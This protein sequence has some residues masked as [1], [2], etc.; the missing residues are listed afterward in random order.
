M[1]G[2]NACRADAPHERRGG[3]PHAF[4]HHP[5]FP[6]LPITVPLTFTLTMKAC[7]S[8]TPSERPTFG[9]LA[10][11]FEDL[12]FEVDT[13]TYISASGQVMVRKIPCYVTL[14]SVLLSCRSPAIR[15]LLLP[16]I[17]PAQRRGRQ[18]LSMNQ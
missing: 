11:I 7:L 9:Q 17:Q 5:A 6:S 2:V 13:G 16:V 4:V 8:E 15:F 3:D 14:R 18:P 10:T 12:V 1:R